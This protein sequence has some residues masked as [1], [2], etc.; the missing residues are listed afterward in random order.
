MHII[1]KIDLKAFQSRCTILR[2]RREEFSS[3]AIA[4]DKEAEELIEQTNLS[5]AARKKCLERWQLLLQEDIDKVNK[6]G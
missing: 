6:K 5:S 3:W 1:T 4:I 2:I